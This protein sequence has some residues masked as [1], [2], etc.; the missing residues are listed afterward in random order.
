MLSV[1]F[2]K[3]KTPFYGTLPKDN[4]KIDYQ[5]SNFLLNFKK[6][7]D[8]KQNMGKIDRVEISSVHGKYKFPLDMK[9]I[10]VTSWVE[11]AGF[12]IK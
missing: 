12:L 2:V 1:W 3:A 6:P 11:A 8:K 5:I 4:A 9:K 10:D 7:E